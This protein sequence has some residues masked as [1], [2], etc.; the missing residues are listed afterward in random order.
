MVFKNYVTETSLEVRWLRLDTFSSALTPRS[1]QTDPGSPL[2]TAANH[3]PTFI[4]V[5]TFRISHSAV[6][7][8]QVQPTPLKKNFFF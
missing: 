5:A 1:Q 2:A 3:P 8:H 4:L 7:D 6:C